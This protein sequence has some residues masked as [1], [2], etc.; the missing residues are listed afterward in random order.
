[1]IKKNSAQCKLCGDIIES[2]YRWNFVSCSCGEIFVDGG[3]DYL[4]RGAKDFNNLL[5]LSEYALDVVESVNFR[6]HTNEWEDLWK[7][8]KV[9]KWV[10]TL[11]EGTI[12]TRGATFDVSS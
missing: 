2:K 6:T 12:D 7:K 10:D 1:M 5:E 8:R 9:E 3:K 11:P 4:R